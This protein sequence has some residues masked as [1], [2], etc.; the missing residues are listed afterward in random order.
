MELSFC[1]KYPFTREAKDLMSSAKVGDEFQLA[2][3]AKR[4]VINA[5]KDGRI[6]L[7]NVELD[8]SQLLLQVASYAVSRMIVSFLKSRYYVNRYAIAEAKRASSYM[9]RDSDENVLHIARE[10]GVECEIDGYY[11]VSFQNYLRYAPKSVD[12]K[13]VNRKLREGVVRLKREGFIRLLE[14]AIKMKIESGLPLRTEGIPDRVKE[15][16]DAVR[17][18]IPKEPKPTSISLERGE[19]PPCISKL[20]E[21]LKTVE[22]LSHT[23]RWA[24]AVYLLNVGMKVDEVVRLFSTSPDFDESVT[25]YQIEHAMKRGYKAPSCASMDSYGL[26]V[27]NCGVKSP[28]GYRRGSVGKSAA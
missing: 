28:L 20:L 14:E 6:P 23:A 25:R 24:L 7:L 8:D 22:N 27:S 15:T 21:D 3:L 16:A 26:C 18:S 10:L 9:E 4:R 1:S 19:F 11:A 17:A 13:L 5:V 12:Y 2:E